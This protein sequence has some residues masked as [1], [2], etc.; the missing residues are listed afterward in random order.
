M[1]VLYDVI[2]TFWNVW[3]PVDFS[4]VFSALI[5]YLSVMTVTLLILSIVLG[6][7]RLLG[8]RSKVCVAVT[9][10]IVVTISVVYSGILVG[11]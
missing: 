1:T 7:L 5:E 3:F 9:M 6:L 10:I 8:V 4:P 2:R 11:G